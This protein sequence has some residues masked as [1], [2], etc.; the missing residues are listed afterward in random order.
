[1][2]PAS[3]VAL[4]VL[5][6]LLPGF[7]ATAI[8]EAL[9]PRGKQSDFQ[10]VISASLYSILIYACFLLVAEGELPFTVANQNS[11]N[12]SVLW[13]LSKLW[14]LLASTVVVGLC[15]A[16]YIN[17]D[18]HALLRFLKLTER[19]TRHSIW[20]DIFERVASKNQIVQV[21]LDG[22]RSIIGVLTYYSDDADDCSLFVSQA[23]WVDQ[24][25]NVIEI[26]GTGILLT[27]NAGIRSVSLLRKES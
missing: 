3:V 13:S 7:A 6:I 9:A 12:A 1:M 10:R 14:L 21:E 8:V 25:G 15:T 19:T 16:A 4:Q 22:D 27:K 17:G 11:S 2:V 24:T 20:N 26:P 23:A 18:G 5:L